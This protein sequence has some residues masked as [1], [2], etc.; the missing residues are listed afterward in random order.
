MK[1][2]YALSAPPWRTITVVLLLGLL[3]ACGGD[4]QAGKGEPW[5]VKDPDQGA[6][7]TTTDMGGAEEDMAGGEVRAPRRPTSIETVVSKTEA[8]AGE[9]LEVICQWIDQYGDPI[10]FD[11]LESP[12]PFDVRRTP[13]AALILGEIGSDV[14]D[15]YP[16]TAA[17]AGDVLITCASQQGGAVD[18]TPARL[19]VKPG[20]AHT[21][22]TRVDRRTMAA[23]EAATVGCQAF[24]AYGNAVLDAQPTIVTDVQGSSV[25]VAGDQV[26]ITS[27]GVYQVSCQVDGAPEQ[28]AAELEVT[29]GLPANLMI[30]AQPVQNVYGLGQ[31]ITIATTVTDQFDNLVP[32]APLEF[33]NSSGG[34][35]FGAGR[36]RFNDEGVHTI[37]ARV[38]PPTYDSR[39]L[40]ASVDVIVNGNGPDITC[41]APYNGEMVNASPGSQVTFQGKVAD[42]NG[43][44][45][46]V[47]NGNDITPAADGTFNLPIT[48]RYGINFVDLVS[49]D[50]YGAENSKTCAFLVSDRWAPEGQRI[51]D[52]ISL[53][54]RQSAI[55]DNVTTDGLDS[56]NDVLLKVL[57]S[58]GLETQVHNALLAANPLK[59]SSCD[60]DTFLGC[61]FRS[62][63]DYRDSAI[64]KPSKGP[65]T[66][67]L[68]LVTD[69]LRL[70]ARLNNFSLKIE[71]SGTL[72]STGWVDFEY[73]EVDLTSNLRLVNGRPKVSLRQ[74]NSV[75]VGNVN[76]NLSG[77]GGVAAD[78]FS[79][80]FQNTLRNLVRDVIRDAVQQQFN[81]ALDGIV[82]GLD[83]SSL[84]SSLNVPRLD[85]TGQVAL[86][87]NVS[88]DTLQVN[89]TRALFGLGAGFTAP[90][91]RAGT[92][93]G[94]AMPGGNTLLDINTTRPIAAAI[95]VGIIN[96]ILHALWR[97]QF[98]DASITGDTL[99]GDLPD[100]SRIDLSMDL[101]P[102]LVLKGKNK[103]ELH[104][105]AA[106]L[107]LVY[108][109]V[110]DDPLTVGLGAVGFTGIIINGDALQFTNIQLSELYFSPEGVSLDDNS[111]DVLEGFLRTLV[112]GLIDRS[113]NN[114]LPSLP[115]PSF[116]L[117]ASMT[118]YGLPA[119]AELGII[120]PTLDNSTTHY[121][122][123]GA[124]GLR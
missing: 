5:K 11:Q 102:V 89:A 71:V 74:I 1:T 41:Q 75:S 8:R 54:L 86:G 65:H 119:N 35:A 107:G 47:V 62:R 23:G 32:A 52:G 81:A 48:V 3:S 84:G 117:P 40:E 85:G 38:K 59:P 18:A 103:V 21:V 94:A 121:T 114:A 57:N 83:V 33:E 108:P 101:P 30:S 28:R 87:F 95:H 12:P 104:L 19:I 113:L 78:V 118:Q 63:I 31:V 46:L 49:R 55:D 88:F 6:D 10:S 98:F 22:V 122:L 34:V 120:Q 64:N 27:T 93:R 124:F 68:D 20:P 14:T 15:T 9:S 50:Q 73:V 82:S 99:S 61:I 90:I 45:L 100:G 105:G 58:T 111:R 29:P 16:F 109:G 110:F 56:L 2:T 123:D 80:F 7:M 112:Q 44:D 96:Q 24:D 53:K 106:R 4:D 76:P 91:T 39:V 37:T 97:A 77:I 115:I 66:T 69:G 25:T 79:F 17:Q 92:T 43:V 26:T 51:G 13:P 116:D 70:K 60:V 67:K 42:V 36:W 72:D